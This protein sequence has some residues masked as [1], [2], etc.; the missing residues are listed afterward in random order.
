MG[1]VVVI[2]ADIDTAVGGGVVAVVHYKLC[3]RAPKPTFSMYM[4]R[5]L[6]TN[7]QRRKTTEW[8]IASYSFDVDC[9]TMKCTNEC[10]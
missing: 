7:R 9:I 1:V 6:E 2:V 10:Y 4:A 5:L 3:P 8:Y